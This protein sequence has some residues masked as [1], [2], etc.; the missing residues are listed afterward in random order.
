MGIPVFFASHNPAAGPGNGADVG[1]ARRRN[2]EL[3]GGRRQHGRWFALVNRIHWLCANR[4]R[5]RAAFPPLSV[6]GFALVN[7]IHWLC[8]Q[9]CANRIRARRRGWRSPTVEQGLAGCK[10]PT[11][12]AVRREKGANRAGRGRQRKRAA[13]AALFVSLTSSRFFP[14]KMQF[15]I[16]SL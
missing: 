3:T 4:T 16:G 13:A 14:P 6:P 9:A 2:T 1:V 11:W 10:A 7:R 15:S 5:A 12:K 8:R